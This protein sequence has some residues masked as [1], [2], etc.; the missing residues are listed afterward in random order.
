MKV[1]QNQTYLTKNGIQTASSQNL[2]KSPLQSKSGG[3]PPQP[4]MINLQELGTITQTYP[5][6]PQYQHH[7]A[8]KVNF[9]HLQN[10]NSGSNTT[11]GSTTT[12]NQNQNQSQH[13]TA[14]SAGAHSHQ[15][16]GHHGQSQSLV[17]VRNHAGSH[18]NLGGAAAGPIIARQASQMQAS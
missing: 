10:M 3:S 17:P 13:W 8:Q 14:S 2:H 5:I 7:Q 11:G 15:H 18:A 4:S 1:V 6:D 9:Y 12:Q 16:H